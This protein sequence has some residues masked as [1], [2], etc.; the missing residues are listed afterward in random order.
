[1]H[2]GET[3]ILGA[4]LK[5]LSTDGFFYK[6]QPLKGI[7]LLETTILLLTESDEEIIVSL[8]EQAKFSRADEL[9]DL[10]TKNSQKKEVFWGINKKQIEE[11]L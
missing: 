4:F 6:G 8:E 5:Q 1:M 3:F 10:I 7:T 11:R 9:L 2:Q